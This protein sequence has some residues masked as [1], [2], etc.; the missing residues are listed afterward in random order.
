LG[1]RSGPYHPEQ[2]RAEK[3][4]RL[5]RV[6][7]ERTM[8][9]SGALAWFLVPWLGLLLAFMPKARRLLVATTPST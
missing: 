5:D 4:R 3:L 7:L 6:V 2:L 1:Y 8:H 9:E